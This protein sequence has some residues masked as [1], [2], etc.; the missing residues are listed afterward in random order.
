MR[1][2]VFLT[3]ARARN[4]ASMT[5]FP[6]TTMFFDG[7]SSLMRFLRLLAVGAKWRAAIRVVRTRFNSSGQGDCRFPVRNPAST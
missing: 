1:G 3:L 6:V 7:I 4:R 2:G 5:V